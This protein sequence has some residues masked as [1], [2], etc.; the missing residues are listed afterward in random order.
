MKKWTSLALT[1][2]LLIVLLLITACAGNENGASSA[3]DNSSSSSSSGNSDNNTAATGK[4]YNIADYY[5]ADGTLSTLGEALP[6]DPTSGDKALAIE[7]GDI[8]I[9]NGQKYI[10]TVG[11][12]SLGFYTQ[13]TMDEVNAWWDETMDRLVNNGSVKAAN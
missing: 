6:L 12:L 13:P 3:S 1:L 8:V 10:V 2:V 7:N 4:T 5:N 11:S 9:V